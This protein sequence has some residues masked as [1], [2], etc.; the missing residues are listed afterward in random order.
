MTTRFINSVCALGLL[1]ASVA[2]GQEPQVIPG[3]PAMNAASYLPTGL[4][5]GGVAQ[6]AR[7]VVLGRDFVE[8]VTAKLEISGPAIDAEVK[9]VSA[10]QIEIMAPRFTSTGTGWVVLNVAGKELRAPIIMLESAPGIRTRGRMGVGQ[11]VAIDAGLEPFTEKAPAVTGDLVRV[12]TTGIGVNPDPARIA[13]IIGGKLNDLVTSLVNDLLMPLVFKPALNAAQVNDIR[14]LSIA[15]I[16]YG[17]VIG[18]FLDFMIVAFVV[19]LI[20]KFL[21][22]E[23]EVAKK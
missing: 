9:S 12:R 2:L 16:F 17:R 23:Q 4:P 20:A 10:K 13:V 19:F 6:G 11:A 1:A 18:A 5:G 14:E 22:R 15:G 7:F 8:P 3:L 21:L